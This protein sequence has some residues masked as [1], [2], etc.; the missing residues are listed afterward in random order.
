MA[1]IPTDEALYLAKRIFTGEIG[2]LE[3]ADLLEITRTVFIVE[4]NNPDGMLLLFKGLVKEI[5]RYNMDGRCFTGVP[6][7]MGAYFKGLKQ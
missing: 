7:K 1:L 2:L 6:Y 5:V 4:S 3:M